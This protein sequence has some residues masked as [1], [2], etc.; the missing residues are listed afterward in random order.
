MKKTLTKNYSLSFNKPVSNG[1][2]VYTFLYI[3]LNVFSFKY[4]CLLSLF[5]R[6]HNASLLSPFKFYL[7]S[8]VLQ[9]LHTLLC[10]LE[11]CC[12]TK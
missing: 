2:V 12:Y 6:L 8:I 7:L 1:I 5:L 11:A 4:S 3:F 9:L 10:Y